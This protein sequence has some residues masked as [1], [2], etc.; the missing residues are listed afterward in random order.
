M[1]T[2]AT[3]TTLLAIILL[4]PFASADM[5]E[6]TETI[7]TTPP[8][9][10]AMTTIPSGVALRHVF[11]SLTAVSSAISTASIHIRLCDTTVIARISTPAGG[12]SPETPFAFA[13]KGGSCYQ[14][15]NIQDPSASN[16]IG[17]YSFVDV[18][19][20]EFE[21]RAHANDTWE[22]QVHANA[23]WEGQVHANATWESQANANQTDALTRN[24]VSDNFCGLEDHIGPAEYCPSNF[25]ANDTYEGQRHAND[26]WEGQVHANA[27]WC[28]LQFAVC[29]GDFFGNFTGNFSGNFSA[30]QSGNF[31]GNFK[32]NFSS[33][34]NG[35]LNVTNMSILG[36]VVVQAPALLTFLRL[37]LWIIIGYFTIERGLWLLAI[38]PFAEVLN[39][40][41][42]AAGAS[43][44]WGEQF[45]ILMLLVGGTLHVLF[46]VLPKVIWPN[47]GGGQ[48]GV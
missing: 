14:F 16:F 23:T 1:I 13:L 28:P 19:R 2:R 15:A 45:S 6:A 48:R 17:R 44:M 36:D 38:A 3:T 34:E 24:Y 39:L 41:F 31:T 42:D 12:D 27:T 4:A 10:G 22:S 11:G 9:F 35:T 33:F 32:G 40:A 30:T 8:A 46:F 29:S 20:E 21:G 7:N 26:T 25:F 5:G 37:T 43:R 47:K 18:E